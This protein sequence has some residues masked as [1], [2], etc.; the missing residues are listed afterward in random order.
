MATLKWSPQEEHLCQLLLPT[1]SHRE[2]AEE[3]TRRFDKGLKGF[4]SERSEDAVRRKCD[5]ED[6]D[7]E[8]VASYT[9]DTNPV[10]EQWKIIEGIIEKHKSASISR[11]RG[12]LQPIQITTKILALS[13]IHF[14]FADAEKLKQAV[15]DHEDAD[16]VVLN[17]DILEG[18]IFSVFDKSQTIAAVDEYR[19]AFAFVEELVGRFPKVVLVDGNHD[20]RAARALK[21]A[22]FPKEA[23]QVFRPNILARIANGEKLDATGM[24]VDKLDFSNVIYQES[25]SW[26]VRI[27]KT[28]F[29]HPHGHGSSTPGMAVRKHA[30]KLNSRYSADEIDSIV[31]GHTHQIYKGVVNGQL[32]IEQGCLASFLKY[33]WSPTSEYT[34]NGQ[35]GYAVIYQ[36]SEGNTDF[37]SSGPVYLGECHPPKKS[38]V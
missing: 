28:L 37:N 31:C 11:S 21:S 24:L 15:D 33:S 14:P 16:I 7:E 36:D 32:L 2:I 4:P 29:I 26:Y 22:N 17:G 9:E 10:Q 25:E 1:N 38:I 19:A 12:I 23:S 27:G 30:L 13:D 35:Q 8:T 34:G 20:V 6:W 18:Y 5:R 3:L